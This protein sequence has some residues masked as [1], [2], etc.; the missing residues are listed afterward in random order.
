M[1][2]TSSLSTVLTP[3]TVALGNFDG[4]HRGH[5]HVIG[6]V[7]KAITVN[8]W[9]ETLLSIET[10]GEESE[11]ADESSNGCSTRP[12]E[13]IGTQAPLKPF[14]MDGQERP[15][16]AT[17]VTFNPHP[18]EF[19]SGQAKALL[20]PPDEKVLQLA[21]MGVEQLV[22]LPFARELANLSAE[23]FVAE[24]LLRQLRSRH[25]SVGEDFRFGRKRAGTAQL[26]QAIAAQ[27]GIDVTIVPL[28]TL[29]GERISSSLIREHL[30]NGNLPDANRLL[31]RSYTLVGSVVQG[32]QLGRKIGFP[33]ANL[34]V[35]PEKFLPR[36]GVY[37][38]RVHTPQLNADGTPIN[39]VMNIGQRP[40]V[41]GLHL[42][43]EVHLFDWSG[44]LYGQ[45]LTVSL[46]QFLRP[47]QKFASLD[48]LKTAIQADCEAARQILM[49]KE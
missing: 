11:I 16:Y 17:V 30:L 5:R 40:T 14:Q 41:N 31:G 12:I 20:T 9:G 23:E 49:V 47:E 36:Y 7:L 3:T 24:I 44:D 48:A 10:T 6:P 32:Q 28:Q 4:V 21:K 39:G 27:D 1:W 43:L 22:L 29:D 13:T 18:Q 34:Q 37:A 45:T 33:T 42:T 2:V 19:F 15:P 25:I 35:P 8:S 38:V 46:E 26:L